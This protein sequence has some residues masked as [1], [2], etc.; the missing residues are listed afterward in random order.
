MGCRIT[1]EARGWPCR[2]HGWRAFLPWETV[3]LSPQHRRLSKANPAAECAIRL[4]GAFLRPH[5][6]PRLLLSNRAL[7]VQRVS[8]KSTPARWSRAAG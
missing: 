7:P 1:L 6:N 5:H 2:M 3:G 8:P 4:A